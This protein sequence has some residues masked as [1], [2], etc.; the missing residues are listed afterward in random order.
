MVSAARAIDPR[1]AAELGEGHHH[2]V[3]PR[4][5]EAGLEP[6]DHLIQL[7]QPCREQAVDA[8]LAGVGVE[9]LQRQRGDREP[10]V[11]DQEPARGD[12]DALGIAG[13]D[14]RAAAHRSRHGLGLQAAGEG[15][16]QQ[17]IAGV[18]VA[19]HLGHAVGVG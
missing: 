18:E 9:A 10:A 1:R 7:V 12:A 4:R 3:A 19:E 8:A 16:A 5:A 2:R 17:R 14:R 6:R 11:R 13:P 15:R